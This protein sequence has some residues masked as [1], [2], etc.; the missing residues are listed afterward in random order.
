ME[1]NNTPAPQTKLSEAQLLQKIQHLTTM[2]EMKEDALEKA[3]AVTAEQRKLIEA[4][5]ALESARLDKMEAPVS[6]LT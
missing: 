6:N 3:L 1:D 4:Y 5:E 2:C